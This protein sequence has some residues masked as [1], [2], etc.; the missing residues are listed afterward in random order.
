MT[1]QYGCLKE[2]LLD[3]DTTGVYLEHAS[4]YFQVNDIREE[5]WVPILLSSIRIR[6]Y[7][8]SENFRVR[9]FS[10]KI[11]SWKKFLLFKRT[12][13]NYFTFRTSH[14]HAWTVYDGVR[15]SFA[16]FVATTS[17]RIGRFGK[18]LSR[19]F[20]DVNKHGVMRAGDI[21]AQQLWKK[22]KLFSTSSR[23]R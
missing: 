18:R 8:K 2:F 15:M 4:L 5:K 6:T 3:E 10:C 13:E 14:V 1:V 12:H 19:K 7:R 21:G 16:A 11:F 9:K 23:G 17:T 22:T 20:C